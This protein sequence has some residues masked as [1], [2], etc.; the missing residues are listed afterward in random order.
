MITEQNLSLDFKVTGQDA[1][2]LLAFCQ[3]KQHKTPSG[4]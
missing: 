2:W 3:K 1:Y 4:I